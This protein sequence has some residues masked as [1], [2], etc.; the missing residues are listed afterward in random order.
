MQKVRLGIVGCGAVAQV[1][2][3]PNLD[4]LRE[5]FSVEIV[6]DLSAT[7]AAAVA[8]KFHIPRHTNHLDEL[9]AADIDAVLLCH[10]DPKTAAAVAAFEAGKHVL[11]EKPICFSLQETD[12]ILSAQQRANTI[13]MAAYMK[14]YDPAF[15]LA[16]NQAQQMS[17][18]R[19]AQIN[20]LH[21]NNSHHLAHF[22]LL[23]AD[24]IPATA[25]EYTRRA[26][27]AAVQQAIGDVSDTVRS[28]FG[29]L[30]GSM[31]HDLYG[32]RAILGVPEKVVST[33]I[34]NDGW[35]INTVFS[36][37]S[38]ARCAA[39]W[40]EL[41]NVREFKETLEI[42]GDESRV[43]LSYPT[44]FSRGILSTLEVQRLDND[45][46]PVR[47]HPAIAW[48]SPFVRELKHFHACITQGEIPRTPLTEVKHD[49]ALII[50]II[51]AYKGAATA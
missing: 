4:T 28:A 24:D 37:A 29:H 49:I 26:R 12:E 44:G 17:A 2:H 34:W 32:L 13:G 35:G 3:L 11:I 6:C 10:T 7:L 1:Q 9:L 39:T 43:L 38:G 41:L 47:E 46:A 25:I 42:C 21:T 33:E 48:E 50:D 22:R 5:E 14:V 16:Q 27:A 31:I 15:E 8:E 19:Y 40:V 45:N 36:Y 20:H 18:I 51:E 30:S 23:R